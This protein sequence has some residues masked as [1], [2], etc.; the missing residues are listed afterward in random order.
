MEKAFADLNRAAA[1]DLPQA[2]RKYQNAISQNEKSLAAFGKRHEG[3][4]RELRAV[5]EVILRVSPAVGRLTES[6]GAFSTGSGAAVGAAGA[7]GA[8]LLSAGKF[9]ADFAV[10]MREIKFGSEESGLGIVQLKQTQL[11]LGE[12]G[13]TAPEVTAN[14]VRLVERMDDAARNVGEFMDSIRDRPK[15][16]EYGY[17]IVELAEVRQALRSKLLKGVSRSA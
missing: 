2:F 11:A 5:Q 17:Q 1:K 4:R 8:A 9:A 14:M 15:F 6:I 16:K 3:V 13:L 10:K 7:M 12:L